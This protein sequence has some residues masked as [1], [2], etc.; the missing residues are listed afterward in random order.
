MTDSVKKRKPRENAYAFTDEEGNSH[1]V[2]GTNEAIAALARMLHD[3][4]QQ[5]EKQKSLF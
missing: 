4:K 1:L 3:A 2:F 5:G